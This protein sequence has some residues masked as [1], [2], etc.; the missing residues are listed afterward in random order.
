M[1]TGKGKRFQEQATQMLPD[2]TTLR[3]NDQPPHLNH[4][5]YPN[6]RLKPNPQ[7]SHLRRLSEPFGATYHKHNPARAAMATMTKTMT[8]MTS[9]VNWP[10]H[11][12][13]K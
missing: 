6:C 3:E 7:R 5:L 13:A 4:A 12:R 11:E 1:A 9:K 2:H 10:Y 8:M